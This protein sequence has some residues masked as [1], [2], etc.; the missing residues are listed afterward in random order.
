MVQEIRCGATVATQDR[1][2][3]MF[4]FLPRL[5]VVVVRE[6]AIGVQYQMEIFDN[7][8]ISI[9][10]FLL[11][12]ELALVEEVGWVLANELTHGL[13]GQLNVKVDEASVLLGF[14]CRHFPFLFLHRE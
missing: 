9:T 13:V 1:V 7:F 12:I 8:T 5:N 11:L 14:L 4:P 6:Q 10:L 3:M 2:L